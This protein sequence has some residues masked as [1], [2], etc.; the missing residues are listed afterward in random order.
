[1]FDQTIIQV[2][3]IHQTNPIHGNNK[4]IQKRSITSTFYSLRV[5]L[6]ITSNRLPT[7]LIKLFGIGF[8]LSVSIDISYITLDLTLLYVALVGRSI[9]RA[10][11]YMITKC[12]L[13]I[14]YV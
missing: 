3:F 5:E 10:C 13:L 12:L 11:V 9:A 4:I 8:Y 1:M 7:H 6:Q 2:E 14:H